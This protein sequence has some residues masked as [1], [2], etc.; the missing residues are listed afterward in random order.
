MIF[1]HSYKDARKKR[2][3]TFRDI[4]VNESDETVKS[5]FEKKVFSKEDLKNI[6][7]DMLSIRFFEEMLCDIKEKKVYAGKKFFFE[8]PCHLAIGQEATAVAEAFYLDENDLIFGS[9][10]SHHEVLAKGFS[11]IRKRVDVRRFPEPRRLVSGRKKAGLE[12][13]TKKSCL[14]PGKNKS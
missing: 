2:T 13:K 12:G 14:F 9:H 1:N 5:A 11:A 8:G 3:I 4:K 7:E 6:Y 10:R